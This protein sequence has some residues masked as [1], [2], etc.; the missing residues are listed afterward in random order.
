ML[1]GEFSHVFSYYMKSQRTPESS[2]SQGSMGKSFYRS[3]KGWISICHL[4]FFTG[5]T[6]QHCQWKPKG[7]WI[8]TL[9]R[10]WGFSH[11]FLINLGLKWE[12]QL[13]QVSL[14]YDFLLAV[15]SHAECRDWS[16]RGSGNGWIWMDIRDLL[17][18]GEAWESISPQQ[19]Q[20]VSLLGQSLVEPLDR[21][22]PL[23]V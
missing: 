8:D 20:K 17:L 9:K 1:V 14:N 15:G 6:C 22:K 16:P 7:W 5:S 13:V 18:E 2:K 11:G 10:T 21:Q 23:W 4:S 19:W 12:V 3:K